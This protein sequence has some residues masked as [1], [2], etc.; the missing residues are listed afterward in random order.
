MHDSEND[1]VINVDNMT[2]NNKNKGIFHF[3][4]D[5]D[6]NYD[7]SANDTI[8]MLLIITTVIDI[9]NIWYMHIIWLAMETRRFFD[10]ASMECCRKYS[11]QQRL[12]Y[13]SV[14]LSGCNFVNNI[15]T[16]T[17]ISKS[18]AASAQHHLDAQISVA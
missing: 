11:L 14:S 8:V 13:I 12:K 2:D 7:A 10:T 9:H 5:N 15:D 1:A 4:I 17:D 16:I 6:V 18:K 3:D